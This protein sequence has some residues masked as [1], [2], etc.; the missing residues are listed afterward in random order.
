[1]VLTS[2][3]SR[4][5][6][7]AKRSLQDLAKDTFHEKSRPIRGFASRFFSVELINR[8]NNDIL[9]LPSHPY[10]ATVDELSCLSAGGGGTDNLAAEFWI[11]NACLR[12]DFPTLDMFS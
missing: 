3:L 1:M 11:A 6:A 5:S 9:L 7:S 8:G 12:Q 10:A 2:A 4:T